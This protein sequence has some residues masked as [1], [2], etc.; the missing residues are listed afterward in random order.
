M[1]GVLKYCYHYSNIIISFQVLTLK[2]FYVCLVMWIKHFGKQ[3]GQPTRS[4]PGW[5][6]SKFLNMH[7]RVVEENAVRLC[8]IQPGDT[9]LELGHGPGLGLEAAAKL[10]TAPTGKLIGVD[11]S[12]YM[13]QVLALKNKMHF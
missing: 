2:R 13:H 6:V 9:V 1:Q 4:L 8:N 3:L 5:L 11:Y 12:E 7:N 10:L